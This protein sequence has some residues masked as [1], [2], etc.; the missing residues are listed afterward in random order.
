LDPPAL[1]AAVR[2]VMA[3][4]RYASAAC[5]IRDE[6]AEMPA[7]DQVATSVIEYARTSR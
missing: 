2:C 3:D 4:R 5:R 1:C 6:I 7:P